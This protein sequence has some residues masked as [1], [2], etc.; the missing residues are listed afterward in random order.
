MASTSAISTK[1]P[2]IDVLGIV[3][4]ALAVGLLEPQFRVYRLPIEP[5]ES[6]EGLP[7][8]RVFNSFDFGG[9]TINGFALTCVESIG[10][11]EGG[12]AYVSRIYEVRVSTSSNTYGEVNRGSGWSLGFIRAQGAFDSYAG[13][14]WE[15]TIDQVYP[16]R[17]MVT[18]YRSTP[19]EKQS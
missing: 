17:V 18:K 11:E 1:A 10:G 15:T 16:H 8:G 2:V 14:Q 19:Q 5:S 4:A 13:I 6:F 3:Q 7:Q 12:G 9:E